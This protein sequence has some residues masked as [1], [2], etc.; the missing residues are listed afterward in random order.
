[1]KMLM[2]DSSIGERINRYMVEC[3]CP[4]MGCLCSI[5]ACINRYMVECE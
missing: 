5:E 2:V 3:E 1:M 4:Y